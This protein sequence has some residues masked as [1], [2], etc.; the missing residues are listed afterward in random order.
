MKKWIVL[1]L[2]AA[3]CL[4]LIACG[5]AGADNNGA[6]GPTED[7]QQAITDGYIVRDS[8]EIVLSIDKFISY[9]EFIEITSE[10]WKEYCE[11]EAVVIEK[12]NA[13][14][15]ATDS[16]TKY[17]LSLKDFGEFTY[18]WHN[19]LNERWPN[20]VAVDFLNHTTNEHFTKNV[21]NGEAF[22][23]EY[24]E[25]TVDDFELLR[26]EGTLVLLM[27]PEEYWNDKDSGYPYVSCGDNDNSYL[28]YQ[29][30]MGVNSITPII[31]TALSEG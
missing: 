19:P 4:A 9:L 1:F 25:C 27:I 16:S 15:E 28:I 12:T 23:Y 11:F 20:T 14:G 5:G 31:E 30:H 10:N 7:A 8:G 13:F 26:I 24:S 6:Q 18:T 17:E 22:L 2:T 3:L 21:A 29:N